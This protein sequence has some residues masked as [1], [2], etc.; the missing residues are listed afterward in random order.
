MQSPLWI[1]QG[2]WAN[3]T[4]ILI[5]RTFP[6]KTPFP[7]LVTFYC[8]VFLWVHC[9]FLKAWTKVLMQYGNQT[10]PLGLNTILEAS[11]EAQH[12]RSSDRERFK[13]ATVRNKAHAG[14][15]PSVR[16]GRERRIWSEVVRC[17]Q[18]EHIARGWRKR[19]CRPSPVTVCSPTDCI[20]WPCANTEALVTWIGEWSFQV[21]RLSVTS[22]P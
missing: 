3:Q 11:E 6:C 8:W 4:K 5:V 2:A 1:T 15:H 22:P 18:P 19:F 7:P 12:G 9:L 13:T 10:L 17:S 14:Y 20:K 16:A 21:T